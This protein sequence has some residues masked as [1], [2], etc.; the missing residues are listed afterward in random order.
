[1]VPS[2]F[3]APP[4]WP[5]L[6]ADPIVDALRRFVSRHAQECCPAPVAIAFSGGADSTALLLAALQLWGAGHVRA[7]HVHHGLQADADRFAAHAQRLCQAWGVDCSLLP[8]QVE[9]QRGDSLEDKARGARYVALTRAARDRGCRW[10]LLGH[11]ADD[12][13]ESLLLALLRGAGPRGLAAMPEA[14]ERHGIWLG[15]P[16]LGCAADA[17]RELLDAQQVP[18]V[19]DAMN[20]D[21]AFRRSRI[22]HELLPVIAR[23]EP[24][25]RNTLARSAQLCALAAQ[26]LDEVAQRD[27]RA[28]S[29]PE[30]L[31]LSALRALPDARLSEVLRLWLEQA[32]LRTHS[33]Q[34]DNL[35][36]QVRATARGAG[37]LR[38][39]SGATTVLRH[40][41]LLV[42]DV[43]GT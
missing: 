33:G 8:V 31:V 12:Q 21:P 39:V 32:G 34:I 7:L 26:T 18:Y 24:G 22:R 43:G 9:L 11:Q 25:W 5:A 29:V 37:K 38:V 20:T 35:L 41:R 15:R 40:G 19:H 42:L 3:T 6:R 2:G 17:L 36:R 13:A 28:C 1:M 27:L 30:G 10:L 4:P 16:L 23:L 14:A